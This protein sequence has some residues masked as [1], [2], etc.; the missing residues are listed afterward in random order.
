MIPARND[1]ATYYCKIDIF[2][3]PSREEGGDLG[4]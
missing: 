1:I 4:N 2:L 3:S